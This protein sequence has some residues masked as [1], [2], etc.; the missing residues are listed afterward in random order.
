M[1]NNHNTTRAGQSIYKVCATLK[2]DFYSVS[3]AFISISAH[4]HPGPEKYDA[5]RFIIATLYYT[6][7]ARSHNILHA[8][9]GAPSA[10]RVDYERNIVYAPKLLVSKE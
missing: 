9:S 10:P 3:L 1:I 5:F 8:A 4:Q 6:V 2:N 7:H